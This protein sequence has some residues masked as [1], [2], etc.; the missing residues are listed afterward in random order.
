MLKQKEMK[1]MA[2]IAGIGILFIFFTMLYSDNLI[3]SNTGYIII[4]KIFTGQFGQFFNEV[5]WSYGLSIYFIY[6]LWSIPVWFI[7]YIGNFEINMNAIPVL[8]WYKLLLILFAV[9]SIFMLGKIAEEI[10]AERKQEVKLQYGVSVF[11]VFP[12]V[13]IAQCDIIG[14]CFVL[15]G[16][17]YY[18]KEKNVLFI[19]AMSVAITMKGFAILPFLPLVL[20]RFRKINKLIS[21]FGAGLLLAGVSELI[22]RSSE[23]GASAR[24]NPEYYVNVAVQRLTEVRIDAGASRVIGLLGFFFVILC[25]MAYILPN[26]DTE[27]NKKYAIW[28]VLA[29]YLSFFLFYNNNLYRHVLLAPF[30]VLAIYIKP[31]L[32]KVCLLLES[33]YGITVVLDSINKQPWV[34][35]GANTFSYLFIGKE[36]LDNWLFT[37]IHWFLEAYMPLILG[38]SYASVI[39]ILVL[40]FPGI[41]DIPVEDGIEKE[42]RIVTWL[43]ISVIFIWIILALIGTVD[44]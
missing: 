43:R 39:A 4:D 22:I 33:L 17:Y 11:L 32:T 6:A 19:I 9:C 10:Y 12:V 1:W 18:I 20:F 42:M 27:K 34:F 8:L 28:L 25:V 26:Q 40:T 15:L 29:S 2:G 7:G 35:L 23:T 14:I 30:L 5:D 31:G 36:I 24:D 16:L 3:N 21:V 41:K 44:F 38:I 37:R 13:A